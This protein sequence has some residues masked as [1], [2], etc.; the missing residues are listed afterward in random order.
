MFWSK[1]KEKEK[2]VLDEEDADILALKRE[3]KL[4]DNTR[5]PCCYIV[6]RELMSIGNSFDILKDAALRSGDDRFLR[7][8]EHVCFFVPPDKAEALAGFP[9]QQFI[10]PFI[11]QKDGLKYLTDDYEFIQYYHPAEGTPPRA[12]KD[13]EYYVLVPIRKV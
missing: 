3:I 7:G 11:T 6:M 8:R 5:F 13:K 12:N 2:K 1:R 10:L 4:L 9:L